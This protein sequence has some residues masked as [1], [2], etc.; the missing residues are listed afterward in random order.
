M[1]DVG[2]DSNAV[3]AA[4]KSKPISF[5]RFFDLSQM[6]RLSQ[7]ISLSLSR[8]ATTSSSEE[9]TATS[10]TKVY[11]SSA[12]KACWTRLSSFAL[13]QLAPTRFLVWPSV[14]LVSP[15]CYMYA[16][17]ARPRPS[18]SF[19]SKSLPPQTALVKVSP[20]FPPSFR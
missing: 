4:M 14:K 16:H 11:M 13:P 8:R 17:R 18:L 12:T 9:V 10:T 1:I 15:A 19:Q 20:V 6:F 2:E 5:R 3:I 7:I